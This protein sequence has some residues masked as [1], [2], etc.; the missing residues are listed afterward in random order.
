[1]ANAN[2]GTVG[3]DVVANMAGMT[4]P[5]EDAA[6]QFQARM[7]AM[8]NAAQLPQK[9][10]ERMVAEAR[11]MG[12]GVAE[13]GV[14]AA[15]AMEHLS[16]ST[17]AARRELLV[18]AH[19]ALQGNWNRFGGSLMVLGERVDAMSLIFSGTG[20]AI[21]AA[22]AAVGGFA[23]AVVKGHMESEAFNKSLLLTGNAAG[24][25]A[26]QF[27]RLVKSAAAAADVSPG[28]AR[29][30]AQALVGSGRVGGDMLPLFATDVSKISKLTG[31]EAAKVAADF[32]KMGDGVAKWA[33]EHNK[34]WHFI[35]SAQYAYIVQLEEVGKRE[36]AEQVVAQ[37]LNDHLTKQAENLGYLQSA[38]GGMKDAASGFW[39]W[40]KSIGRDGTL[41]DQAAVAAQ[42]LRNAQIEAQINARQNFGRGGGSEYDQRAVAAAQKAYDDIEAK[43]QAAQRKA[44][45]QADAARKNEAAITAQNYIK[46]L[47][48]ELDTTDRLTK[49]LRDYRREVEALKGTPQAISASQQAADEAAIRKKYQPSGE[50]KTETAFETMRDRLGEENARLAEQIFQW[51]K[52]GAALDKARQASLEFSISQGKLKD[53]SPAQVSM[54]RG[55]A[56]AADD[57]ERQVEAL[58]AADSIQKKV[59][60]MAEEA[61]AQ[62][63]GVRATREAALMHELDAQRAHMS[64]QAYNELAKSIKDAAG[65]VADSQM[66]VALRQQALATD[67]MIAKYRLEANAAGMDALARQEMTNA[68]KSEA[69]ARALIE[70]YPDKSA[71]IIQQ[72][73]ADLQRLNAALEES[74]NKQRTWSAGWSKAWTD[75]QSG[76]TDASKAA[77][78]VFDDF[79]S[80]TE[81]AL[82]NF[83]KSGKLSFADLANS[84]IADLIRVQIQAAITQSMGGA[85]T[86][87]ASIAGAVVG[88]FSGSGPQ[89]SPAPVEN[90]AG[91]HAA[92]L[93]YVPHDNYVANLHKGER[94]LTAQEAASYRGGGAMH[95]APNVQVSVTQA[96]DDSAEATG[97]KISA[98]VVRQMRGIANDMIVQAR[99]QGG[100]LRS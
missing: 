77:S 30:A 86:G 27:D 41:E 79:T 83:V 21:G 9:Q 37:A 58:K 16:F 57:R 29:D 54:L 45:E 67:Q 94:V 98:E 97:Q 7:Q 42:R 89:Q 25:T 44:Q 1:M 12:T 76:A 78:R 43:V 46:N 82:M 99:R 56:A 50:K 22:A 34:A 40:A 60:A 33:E 11:Q 2:I 87:V 61:Q 74:Y 39:D 17:T 4:N 80:G 91:S 13:Q 23:L 18:L 64:A 84:I 93:A 36:Q 55:L 5:V 49:A 81:S 53:A 3:I 90:I 52:Y 96:K 71:E 65:K 48:N 69:E 20:L 28:S 38:W 88:Y 75:Y 8:A 72:K 10:F 68:I 92:G 32:A 6:R 15:Q 31:E 66:A 14:K 100:I 51:Q 59:K 19:E 73:Q 70:K 85:T 24:I 63:L 47:R 95:F 62:Q 26:G 35:D